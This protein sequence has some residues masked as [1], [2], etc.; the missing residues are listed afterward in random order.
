MYRRPLPT[1]NVHFLATVMW[2]G[3][4]NV[5]E[6]MVGNLRH[7]SNEATIGHAQATNPLGDPDRASIVDFELGKMFAQRRVRGLDL[8]SLG[9]R[10]GAAYIYNQVRPGFFI[11]IN[12]PFLPGF[13]NVVF[14]IYNQWEPAQLARQLGSERAARRDPRAPIGRGQIV[15]NTK[16][17]NIT[18]VAGLNGPNDA[19]QA[20][21]AGFCGTCHDTPN[22]GNHSVSLPLDI[23]VASPTPVGGLDVA[24]LPVYT[25]RRNTTGETF[26]TTD[27]GRGVISGRWA[28]LGRTKGP[29][30]RGLAARAP[31]FHNGAAADL[32]TVVNFYDE[33]FD[34][35]FTDQEKSDLQAF[36]T[37]L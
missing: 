16:P 32:A 2:D 25:F 29:I 13:T 26:T 12:D 30:L 33:R 10:G 9:A 31:Y 3:R 5:T 22:I 14:T 21:I 35:G 19:S 18:D 6:T 36:L 23:G 7:Q 34:V 15:F 27:P 1:A 28:D 24:N 20:P 4:E 37:A 11:G 8:R 17:I